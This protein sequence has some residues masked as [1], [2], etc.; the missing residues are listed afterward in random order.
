M[1]NIHAAS[2]NYIKMEIEILF[3]FSIINY[4]LKHDIIAYTYPLR[5]CLFELCST[6]KC[7]LITG[8]IGNWG[9]NNLSVNLLFYFFQKPVHLPS[10][11]EFQ[12]LR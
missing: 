12:K 7:E 6:E 8:F 10:V 3:D 1:L 4:T 9:I 2:K 11:F 5:A